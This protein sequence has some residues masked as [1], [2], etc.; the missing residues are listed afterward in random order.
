MSANTRFGNAPLAQLVPNVFLR[1]EFRCVGR[2]AE[3][4]TG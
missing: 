2:Q 4:L 1:V 3:Q